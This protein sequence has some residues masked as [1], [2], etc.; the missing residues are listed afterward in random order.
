MGEFW[1]SKRLLLL[2]VAMTLDLL[3]RIISISEV[4]PTLCCHNVL[5][6][7]LAL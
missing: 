7:L 6:T 5:V 2:L 4:S 3:L 1:N